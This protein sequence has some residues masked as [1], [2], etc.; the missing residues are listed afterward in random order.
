MQAYDTPSKDWH[1][2]SYNNKVGMAI[3]FFLLFIVVGSFFFLN[4]FV[5]VLFLKFA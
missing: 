1:G 2:P 5:G 4:M 3:M